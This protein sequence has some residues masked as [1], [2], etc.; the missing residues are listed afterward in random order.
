[1]LRQFTVYLAFLKYYRH[2]NS[3]MQ[4]MDFCHLT[5]QNICIEV[6]AFSEVPKNVEESDLQLEC[7]D[8]KL[9]HMFSCLD[10]T[11]L[12]GCQ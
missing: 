3:D 10:G 9:Y 7:Q 11:L 4:L 6:N 1:M 5:L 12:L 8:A 2:N